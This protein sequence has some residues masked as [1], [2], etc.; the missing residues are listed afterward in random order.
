[1]VKGTGRDDEGVALCR[2]RTVMHAVTGLKCSEF[3]LE[4]PDLGNQD[5]TVTS[6]DRLLVLV[7]MIIED[8]DE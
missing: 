6:V 2:A 8:E 4:I 1:M 5:S 3:R 7:A